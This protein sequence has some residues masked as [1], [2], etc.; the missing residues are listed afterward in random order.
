MG[1]HPQPNAMS[2][3]ILKIISNNPSYTPDKIK[4]DEA[5]AFLNKIYLNKKKAFITTEDIE[6]VDQGG[7]F[8]S[9]TCNLCG[10]NIDI[11]YWQDA[12]DKASKK[13]FKDLSFT[14][15]CCHKKTSLNDLR[16]KSPAGFAKFVITITDPG[17][18]ISKEDLNNLEKIMGTSLRLVWAHY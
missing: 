4:Q 13:E 14:T 6:F 17:K 10:R 1:E 12:V 3:T 7:N 2:E 11:D 5:K 16:Y 18:E 8:D 9:I 15:P